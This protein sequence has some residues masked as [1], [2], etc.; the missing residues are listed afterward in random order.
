MINNGLMRAQV[1]TLTIQAPLSGSG[2]LQVD[3]SGVANLANG[4]KSQGQLLMGAA[5]AALN[6]GTGNLTISSDYTNAGAGTGNS[7]NRR[8]GVS[9]TGQIVAGGNA[10]Q[11]IT[12]AGVANGNTSN[13]T[14]TLGNMRVGANTFNYQVANTGTTGPTL[15]GAIQTAANGGN[16]S[17]ARLSGAGVTAA[18]YNAGAPAGNSGN[19]GVTFTAAAAG[20]LAPLAG[21]VIN[22][23]SNFENIADQKL[24]IVLAGGAAAYNAAVGSAAPA[25]V[26]VANQRVGGT[27]TAALT[28]SNQAAAGA[29]SEDLIATFGSNSGHAQNNGGSLSGLLAG[30]SN[31][32]ALRVGVDTATAG[33]KVG[34]VTINYQTAGAVNGVSN[35]LGVAG[36]N[37]PQ[38]IGVSGN[39]YQAAA[40]Q[41]M[42]APLNFGTVQVG[43][44]VTQNLVVRNSASGATGFVEDLN[45]SFGAASGAGASLIS[46]TGSFSGIAAGQNS[47]AGNG[48]MQ[49]SV[50]TSAAGAV[51]GAIAVNYFTAGAVGGLSN[52]L[53]TA[54]VGSDSFGVQG[55]I[56][57]NANVIN[58]AS[59]LINNPVINLGAVRV[60]AVAPTGTVSVSN[61]AT[62]AP[63]AALNASIAPATGP[64]SASGSFNLLNP[65]ATNNSN[66]VVGLN[67]GTAGNYTGANAGTA[68]VSFVSD[69]SN[70]G[71]CAPNC[72]LNLAPQ[73]VSVAG[74]VYAVAAGQLGSSTVDF[75]IVRVGDNVAARQIVVQNTAAVAGLNDT[76]GASVSGLAGP[77]AAGSVAGVAAQ[78][79]GQMGVTLN[80][81]SAGVF[82]QSGLVGFMS[83]NADMADVQAGADAAVAITA[84]VNNLANAVFDLAAGQG[85]LSHAGNTF[86]L[87][88]GN[89]L[90]GSTVASTLSLINQV[91]GP[92]DDLDGSFDS[93]GAGAF[94]LAGWNAFSGLAAGDLLSG[95]GLNYFA[96][97]LGSFERQIVLNGFS[98]NASDPSGIAQTINLVLRGRVVGANNAVP[99]PGSL[100]LV[101]L[102]AAAGWQVRRRRA[103]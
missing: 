19:L 101:L 60:G 36:A 3:A 93:S 42:S 22:L 72:T 11:A 47:N 94:S 84:Q 7:F 23:R 70:V 4:A 37:A 58:Q 68:T 78:A 45:A 62:V 53:G 9:G 30:A 103:A 34:T 33:A 24:N 15:R 29:F 2:T 51:S 38:Q 61:V 100:A 56:Q 75:G 5:G 73:T 25:P 14:L 80:T 63:Q 44:V 99:E 40:G 12:G 32:S 50:N 48:S 18:N 16:I 96:A 28:I 98:V 21:Q 31:G 52:G 65:G 76:L 49:V 54:A 86:Y 20:A 71:N 87:D 88:Y 66:L 79:S 102:A 81:S 27:T 41:L 82:S 95:L 69:A 8:A 74:K 26:T 6:L 57:A 17:D 91:A 46:G 39:V 1:G 83:Q 92:A 90:E 85:N 35:G 67:T 97:T 64:V 13:A 89:V 59:P 43:Q 55:Q 77:F 10:A